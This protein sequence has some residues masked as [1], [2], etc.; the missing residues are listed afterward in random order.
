M[1]GGVRGLVLARSRG[2]RMLGRHFDSLNH[3]FFRKIGNYEAV[4]VA[5]C[6]IHCLS[7][8]ADHKRPWPAADWDVS[9]VIHFLEIDD[10]DLMRS[11]GAH[12]YIS[13]AT[14]IESVVRLSDRQ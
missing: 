6:D 3:L 11:H 8:C 5:H 7:I 14:S 1:R 10:V 9:H 12:E 13:I 4:E 2:A